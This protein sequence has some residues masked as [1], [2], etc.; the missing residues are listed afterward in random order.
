MEDTLQTIS[1]P[2]PLHEDEFKDE[3]I[4]YRPTSNAEQTTTPKSN[5]SAELPTKD[6]KQLPTPSRT[7]SPDLPETIATLGGL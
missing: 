4:L 6:F 5:D 1:L 2:E 3:S 7:E